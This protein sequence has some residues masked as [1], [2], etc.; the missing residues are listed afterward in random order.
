M[1]WIGNQVVE[2]DRSQTLVWDNFQRGQEL[3]DQ[4]GSRSSKFLIGTV[5][6]AHCVEPFLDYRWDD[7]NIFMQYDRHQSH[8]S[9]LGMRAYELLDLSSGSFGSD[10]FMNH[11][12]LHVPDSPCFSSDEVHCYEHI[13][14]VRKYLCNMSHA[15]SW[16]F[17]CIG[18]GINIDNISKFNEYCL[19]KE[20]KEFF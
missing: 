9:P 10:V 17:E 18:A 13:I 3:W 19:S 16:Q 14:S 1:S 20:S 7:P 8:P 6:A 2:N 15:F 4:Q 5:E 12:N 11:T